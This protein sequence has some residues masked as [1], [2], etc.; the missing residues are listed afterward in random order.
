MGELRTMNLIY[1]FRDVKAASV[2]EIEDQIFEWW[3]AI[4]VGNVCSIQSASHKLFNMGFVK[5]KEESIKIFDSFGEA[6]VTAEI[7]YR[8]FDLAI[9][10]LALSKLAYE[11]S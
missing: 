11:V 10:K 3:E 9:L 6:Q 1:K 4:Q 2:Y 5:T 7:W 8:Y